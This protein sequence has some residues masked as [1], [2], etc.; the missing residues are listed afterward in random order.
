[1]DL[2]MRAHEPWTLHDAEKDEHDSSMRRK[3]QA[4]HL[5]SAQ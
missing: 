4:G 3:A 2:H 1:M 5:Q